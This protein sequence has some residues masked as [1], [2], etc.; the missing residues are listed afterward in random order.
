MVDRGRQPSGTQ[1]GNRDV[2]VGCEGEVAVGSDG[3]ARGAARG[4]ADPP[5]H[6]RAAAGAAPGG[7]LCLVRVERGH[8]DLPGPG[9]AQH[10]P[11]QP[12]RLRGLLPIPRPDHVVAAAAARPD[13]GGPGDAPVATGAHRVLPRLPLPGRPVLGR[14]SLRMGWRSKHRRHAHLAG[15]PA[16]QLRR[17]IHR[18]PGSHSPGLHRRAETRPDGHLRTGRAGRPGTRAAE[19]AGGRGGASWAIGWS[20]KAIARRLGI[21]FTTVRTHLGHAFRKLGVENRVQ[22]ASCL[23]GAPTASGRAPPARR[24]T[25]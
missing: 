4:G 2:P 18:H 13:A 17:R 21:G 16:R 24:A 7:P 10:V 6:R 15:P 1:G 3:H 8:G 12:E 14:Q 20:D 11:A 9:G 25:S 5:A 23:A 19:R 22:L